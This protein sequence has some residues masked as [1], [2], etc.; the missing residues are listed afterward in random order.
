[1]R[2]RYYADD[3]DEDRNA[4]AVKLLQKITEQT[5]LTVEVERI[6]EKYSESYSDF[7][8]VR[9]GQMTEV[10]DRDFHRNQT[11]SGNIRKTPSETYK[12][13]S[14]N[15][16]IGGLVGV[17]RDERPA[18]VTPWS[19]EKEGEKSLH[20]SIN[21][22][23]FI[24]K[25]GQSGVN[26]F[27]NKTAT[28]NS[29]PPTERVVRNRFTKSGVIQGSV[30]TEVS[31]GTLAATPGDYSRREQNLQQSLATRSVDLVVNQPERDWV[32]EIK[33]EYDA[34]TFDHVFGQVLVSDT[35]YRED[36]N[37]SE[38][39]T[40]RVIVFGQLKS[41]V[42]SSPKRRTFGRIVKLAQ[43]HDVR[44][45]V[46]VDNESFEEVSTENHNTIP[47]QAMERE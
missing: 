37:L 10:Y 4:K 32:V 21:F 34:G 14:G 35:L 17:V 44:I 27:L 6:R 38:D 36:N 25:K 18:Y 13:N 39:D 19:G 42:D 47:T 1:M 43:E 23:E 20:H 26:E 29:G 15:I 3:Y 30:Q 22:L 16:M 7:D 8:I 40:Q 31:V 5:D 28:D 12:T 33:R 24:L 9:S 2:L 46:G 45:F 11:L 41:S